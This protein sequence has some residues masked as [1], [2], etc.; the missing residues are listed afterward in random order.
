MAGRLTMWGAGQ[1]LRT[2]FSQTAASP[3]TFYLALVAETVPSAYVTG[4]EL[5]ELTAPSYARMPVPND[6]IT[7]SSADGQ[8]HI[9]SNTG[10]FTWITAQEEWGRIG[11]WALC[12][13]DSGGYVYLIGDFEEEQLIDAGDQVI[14]DTDQIVIELGPFFTA[15]DF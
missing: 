10:A 15:E 3:N 1:L 11:Y 12:D 5:D 8:L 13:A 6:A 4:S 14:I 7:W 2:F 9:I